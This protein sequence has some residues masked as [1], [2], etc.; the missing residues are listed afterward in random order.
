MSYRPYPNADRALRYVEARHGDAC[1]RCGHAPYAHPRR[2][3]QYVCSRTV[4]GLPSCREC[5]ARLRRLRTGP[6]GGAVESAARVRIDVPSVPSVSAGVDGT[7]LRTLAQ[8]A[9]GQRA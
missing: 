8:R 5:A 2:R 9:R 7:V 3:G 6:L 1:P 4:Q